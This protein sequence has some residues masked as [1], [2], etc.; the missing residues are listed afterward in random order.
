[1]RRLAT[2]L[3]AKVEIC[4][5]ELLAKIRDW[6]SYARADSA[7]VAASGESHCLVLALKLKLCEGPL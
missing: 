2:L 4:S 1:V 3:D 5:C 7:S 6:A